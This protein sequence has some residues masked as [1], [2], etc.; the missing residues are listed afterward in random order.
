[1]AYPLGMALTSIAATKIVKKIGTKHAFTAGVAA[2]ATC[3]LLFGFAPDLLQFPLETSHTNSQSKLL[4]FEVTLFALYFLNGLIGA[5]AETSCVVLLS[6]RFTQN[7]GTVMAHVNT[8]ATFG[9]LVGTFMGGSLYDAAGNDRA[10]AFRLPFIVSTSI[11]LLLLPFSLVIPDERL[12]PTEEPSAPLRSVLSKSVVLGLTAVLASAAVLGTLDTDLS[13]RLQ[14]PPFWFSMMNIST[15]TALSSAGYIVLMIPVADAAGRLA[16]SSRKLKLATGT[17]FIVLASSFALLGPIFGIASLN[18]IGVIIAAMA[19]RS[20]GSSV[21]SNFVYPDL[22]FGIRPFDAPLQ[23]TIATL[24]NAAYALGWALGPFLG[25]ALYQYFRGDRE[26]CLILDEDVCDGIDK[27]EFGPRGCNCYWTRDNG[28]VGFANVVS[29]FC[30]GFGCIHC[31][32]AAFNVHDQ[33]PPSSSKH[34]R[35]I[36]SSLAVDNDAEGACLPVSG[37]TPLPVADSGK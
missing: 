12:R 37:A 20:L 34:C 19:L 31:V 9:C 18:S 30:L 10:M 28:F 16:T 35:L 36:D 8:S 5:M 23:A 29:L 24:W 32:A 4:L 2:T 13:Y 26:L 33:R 11:T 17:G 6:T 15:T 27:P 22:I 3:N 14:A 21:S 7:I 25:G 1:M